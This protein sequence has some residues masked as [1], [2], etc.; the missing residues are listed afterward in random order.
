MSD[1]KLDSTGDLQITDGDLVLTTTTDRIDQYVRQ[2]LQTFLGEF[3][4][5]TRVGVPY[6][7]HILKKR[8]DPIVI[9]SILKKEI[10]E[11]PGVTEIT[12]FDLDL[13]SQTRTLTLNFR[14]RTTDGTDIVFNE[15]LA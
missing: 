13:D 3:F 5:D 8:I 4:L 15:E 1:L 10:I 11:T 7:E 9:D 2:R 12:E 14:A 6:F